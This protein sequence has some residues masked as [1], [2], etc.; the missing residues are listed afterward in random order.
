MGLPDFFGVR[1]AACQ[2]GR[3]SPHRTTL[4]R[5]RSL[6]RC[7]PLRTARESCASA[8]CWRAAPGCSLAPSSEVAGAGSA[9]P[10]I[11]R[12]GRRDR[13]SPIRKSCPTSRATVPCDPVP[14]PS[15]DIFAQGVPFRPPQSVLISRSEVRRPFAP[16]CHARG[17]GSWRPASR[18]VEND[19]S[20]PRRSAGIP[21]RSPDRAPPTE[22]H[23]AR[24]A[25]PHQLKRVRRAHP[26]PRPASVSPV[27]CESAPAGHP[28]PGI[29]SHDHQTTPTPECAPVSVRPWRG[30]TPSPNMPGRVF[31]LPAG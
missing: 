2:R 19:R 15:E 31:A 21:F 5:T 9:S 14:H 4:H 18:R 23:P 29:A 26:K 8:S 12:G 10:P 3:P 16:C 25:R 28:V 6:A 17:R 1:R 30:Q 27:S 7:A 24:R 20:L 11:A 22:E 13:P